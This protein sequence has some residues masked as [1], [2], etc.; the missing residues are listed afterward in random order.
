MAWK[1]AV[2]SARRRLSS[3]WSATL[4]SL[5]HRVFPPVPEV[6]RAGP[7]AGLRFA[8]PGDSSAFLSGQYE[9]PVQEALHRI[10]R[11]GDTVFDVGANVGFFT[12]LAARLAGPT[13]QV[14]AFEPVPGNVSTIRRNLRL[15]QNT[16]VE[17]CQAAVGERNG[18]AE[19]VLADHSGGAALASVPKPPDARGSI[20][21]KKVTLDEVIASRKFPPPN[22]VKIDVEGAELQVLQG[23][24]NTLN[25]LRPVVLLEFDG[26]ESEDVERRLALASTILADAGY[27]V[28]RL[29][30]AY[31]T[32]WVVRH[33]L[34]LPATQELEPLPGQ[35]SDASPSTGSG[36]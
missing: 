19:L 2:S 28:E 13:G 22:V 29:P 7:A 17:I 9:L 26:P 10:V 1:T 30:D 12:L 3:R 33:I 6:V 14:L 23:M 11:P 35:T 16:N 32:R 15:N 21:V 24:T 20:Q 8:A 27:V 18:H 4:R 31:Q 5:G 36:D 34:A 25:D